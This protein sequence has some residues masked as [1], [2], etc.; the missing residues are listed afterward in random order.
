MLNSLEFEYKV[1]CYKLGFTSERNGLKINFP[2]L[3]K[4]LQLFSAFGSLM[5]NT[6]LIFHSLYKHDLSYVGL[7]TLESSIK[8]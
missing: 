5:D 6:F 2:F 4:L 7:R 1:T 8:T 3:C